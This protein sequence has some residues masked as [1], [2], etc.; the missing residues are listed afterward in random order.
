MAAEDGAIVA[1]V[2]A[3]DA[4]GWAFSGNFVK[5]VCVVGDATTLL[6]HHILTNGRRLVIRDAPTSLCAG[7]GY[8][9]AGD[10]SEVRASRGPSR[11]DPFGAVLPAMSY[12]RCIAQQR[13]K[14]RQT[15]ISSL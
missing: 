15:S 14:I 1:A 5:G 8:L 9:Y 11:S 2:A 10:F 13:C 7:T 4:G 3:A 12:D 6:Y